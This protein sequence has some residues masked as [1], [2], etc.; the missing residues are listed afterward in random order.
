MSH[1]S[2]PL[3]LP[4]RL[5]PM[6]DPDTG[7]AT[8]PWYGFFVRLVSLAPPFE[9]LTVGASPFT[10]RTNH[11]GHFLVIGNATRID[12]IRG[13]I[14]IGPTGLTTGMIPVATG[15]FMTIYYT[16][17]PV[18]WFIAGGVPT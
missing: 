6:A 1:E 13:R 9:Q 8:P 10:V 14:T 18:I 4:I 16:V 2:A 17:L 15:D 11:P 3:S 12:L 7:E 5:V